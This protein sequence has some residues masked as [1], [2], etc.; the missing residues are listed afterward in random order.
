[1]QIGIRL[2]DTKPGT[3]EERLD[4]AREQGFSCVHLALSKVL[5]EQKAGYGSLTPGYAMYIRRLFQERQLDIAVLGCYLNLAHP[6]KEKRKAILRTYEAH[7]R[8]ASI[9]GCGV[10]GTETGAPNGEYQYEP[11]CHTEEARKT[12]LTN[13]KPVIKCA[14]SYGVTLAIEPVW[15]HIVWNP[16]V[17]RQV[18]EE[19]ASPNLSII[20]DPVNLMGGGNCCRYQEV[21]L[22]ALELLGEF[23]SVI[24]IKDFVLEKRKG[25]GRE[26]TVIKSV[27]AGTG[28]MD[29]KPLL[30]F[31]K[32]KKPF[33]HATLEDTRPGNAKEAREYIET[34]YQELSLPG[35]KERRAG[36]G[37]DN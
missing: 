32:E 12:F 14:E 17:A 29:Y 8:F 11:A 36:N 30:S 27:A 7:I 16:A 9:L 35:K 10:V 18:L 3:L 33:I 23:I 6:D 13:L 28:Q 25:N 24:H 15:N 1:M 26:E 21:L 4:I 19:I 22:E 31:I 2:H 5:P 20:L 34:L 37:S